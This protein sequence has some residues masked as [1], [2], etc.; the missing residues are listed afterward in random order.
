MIIQRTVLMA[1][2]FAAGEALAAG[3]TYK[4]DPAHSSIGF[5][6]RHMGISNVKGQFTKF[7]GTGSFDEKNGKVANIKFTIDP[8]SV[9]TREADRDKHLRTSDFFDVEKH[10]EMKFESTNVI[11]KGSKPVEILG[12]LTI[13]GVTKDVKLAVTEWGGTTI[14][15]WGNERV[16]FSA[17]G[18]INRLDFGVSWNKPLDKAK[19]LTVGNDVEMMIEVEAIKDKIAAK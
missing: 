8:A 17:H 7:E 19:G 15:P 2:F 16:G 1:L 10:K 11:T 18:K 13:K 3:A 5:K 14:D 12:K 9:D 6:V 4:V